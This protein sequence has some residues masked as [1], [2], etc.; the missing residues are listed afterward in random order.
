MA[1]VGLTV[2]REAPPGPHEPA[3]HDL[4]EVLATDQ[5]WVPVT[6]LAWHRLPEPFVQVLSEHVM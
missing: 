4:A 6:V 3:R 1:L 2:C 5:T